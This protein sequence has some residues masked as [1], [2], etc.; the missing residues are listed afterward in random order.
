[1]AGLNTLVIKKK[2]SLEYLKRL[3]NGKD[4]FYKFWQ[5]VIHYKIIINEYEILIAAE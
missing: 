2:K 4:P 5:R 1:M 3:S